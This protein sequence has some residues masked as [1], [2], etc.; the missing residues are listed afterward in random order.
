MRLIFPLIIIFLGYFVIQ[1][2]LQAQVDSESVEDLVEQIA[3]ESITQDRAR[4]AFKYSIRLMCEEQG[5]DR[6][7]G[8]GSVSQCLAALESHADR[9][10]AERIF[11]IEG[12]DYVSAENLQSDFDDYNRC[13]SLDLY[14]RN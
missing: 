4:N 12:L 2:K 14:K 9:R 13:A 5:V 8:F 10:C 3:Y 1:E 7:N 6:A 11:I